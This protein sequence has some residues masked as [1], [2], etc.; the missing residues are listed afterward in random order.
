MGAAGLEPTA[1]PGGVLAARGFRAAGVAAGIKRP[2]RLDVCI[3]DAGHPVP[4][5]AVFTKNT[6]AAPPVALSRAAHVGGHLR[7]WVVNAGNANA[8]TGTPGKAD[9]L[10]MA[11]STAAHLGCDPSEVAVAS[12]GVIGVPLPMERVYAGIEGAAAALG[13]SSDH[14]SAAA[15]AIMTTDTFAKQAAFS[16]SLDDTVYTVGGMAKGS[17]MIMPNMATMLGFLTTDA[18]LTPEACHAALVAAADVTFNRIT[19]DGDTST[20]DT[21]ALMASGAAGGEPISPDS[22]HFAPA[23][24]A[25]REGCA[26]P[27]R[28]IVR[29]GEGATK[30]VSVTVNGAADDAD[31]VAAARA[32]ANSPLFKTALFGR[33]AN[34]G[35]V[36]MAVGNSA[37]RIDPAAV[38]ITFAGILTCAGGTAVA[39]SEEEAAAALAAEEVEVVVDLHLGPGSATVLTCDLTYE[40]VRINGAYRT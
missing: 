15:E 27:A 40:Y 20:N 36:A 12:T 8:C 37:A 7:A 38:D 16:V 29:D 34:W 6:M 13:E 39:F 30:L 35:R 26:T 9:A 10:A 21:C 2:G 3:I 11:G 17:G 33:D 19:V 23:A 31:A 5:A 18:P 24:A 22:P 1:V 14:D 28:M 4:A 32:V 25:V